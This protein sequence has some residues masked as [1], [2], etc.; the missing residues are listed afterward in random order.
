[1]SI[2]QQLIKINVIKTD[3]GC[4]I[5]AGNRNINYDSG[6]ETYLFDGKPGEKTYNCHWL[7]VP[8]IPKRVTRLVPQPP[9]NPR[10]ELVDK[11]MASEKIPLVV[12]S[13]NWVDVSEYLRSLY[14]YNCDVQP[15]LEVEVPVEYN[16]ILEI[17]NIKE[18]GGFS[19]PIQKTQWECDG[20]IKLT[21]KDVRHEEIDTIIFPG[22]ILPARTSFL[23]SRQVYQIVRKHVQDNI[24]PKW[25]K[26]T[27]DYDFCFGVAKK[28]PLWRPEEYKR[29]ILS[30]RSR[31]S[32]YVTDYRNIREITVFEMTYSPENY[33]GYTPISEIR[34][35]NIEDLKQKVDE[36]LADLIERINE[37]LKDCVHCKGRGVI[38]EENAK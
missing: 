36:F 27:S 5:Q 19:Y 18:Y 22:I 37:P 35:K 17:D 7:K 1:M 10:Y 13:E 24:D 34:G 29:N 32:K 4:Y 6:L 20:F 38:L 21:D 33:K 8:K 12:K 15:N 28:I 16:V 14:K 26:I 3:N 2:P 25:A 30:N 9:I 31:K 11:E 23:T